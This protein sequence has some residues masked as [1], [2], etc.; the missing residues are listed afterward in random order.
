MKA[1]DKIEIKSKSGF[2]KGKVVAYDDYKKRGNYEW[3]VVMMFNY[4][5]RI[6]DKNI[7]CYIQSY[8]HTKN[9]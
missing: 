2:A 4:I 7:L 3:L 5:E 6:I 1:G 8:N 9:I